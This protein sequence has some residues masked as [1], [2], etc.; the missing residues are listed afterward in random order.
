MRTIVLALFLTDLVD[1]F[2]GPVG[3]ADTGK[4]AWNDRRCRRCHGEMGEGGFG[5]DLAGRALTFNQFKQ[6]LRKPWG[7]MPTFTELY[8]SDQVIADLQAYLM[9]LP[10]VDAPGEWI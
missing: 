9:T 5:P 4:S 8:T 1:A 10:K 6:A 7:I 3:N 2:D